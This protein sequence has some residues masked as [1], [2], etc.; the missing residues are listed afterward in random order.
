MD[1]LRSLEYFTTSAEEG[2]FSAAARRLEVSVPAVAK[3]VTALER[4]LGTQLFERSPHGLMLTPNG[5]D[6]LEQCRP[7]L[8]RLAQADEQARAAATRPRGTVVVGVQQLV[9]MNVLVNALPGFRE[10]YPDI[11]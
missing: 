10:R 5:E 6:Y 4:E 8:E 11:Q 9:A 3:L 1:K 2:S 7:A